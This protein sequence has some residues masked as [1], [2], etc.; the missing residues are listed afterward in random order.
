[1]KKIAIVAIL[2]LIGGKLLGQIGPILP[3]TSGHEINE[4]IAL[5]LGDSA[6]SEE[7]R[8]ELVSLVNAKFIE[9]GSPKS[10]GH[11]SASIVEFFSHCEIKEVRLQNFKNSQWNASTQRIEWK[12]DTGY[13]DMACVYP[14]TTFEFSVYKYKCANLTNA[15]VIMKR[16][17]IGSMI[18]EIKGK[19]E[20]EVSGIIKVEVDTIVHIHRHTFDELP[21][22]SQPWQMPQPEPQKKKTFV[23]KALAFIVGALITGTAVYFL[24]K[25]KKQSPG[26]PGSAPTTGET[27]SP[28]AAPTTGGSG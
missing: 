27:G 13:E 19:I 21:I 26:G 20:A 3:Y 4:V 18:N 12:D 22:Q 5:A 9:A 16:V 24:T 7:F 8:T 6:R 10:L 11:D 2:F 15:P 28:G 23:G 14:D 1:M 25:G 17:N